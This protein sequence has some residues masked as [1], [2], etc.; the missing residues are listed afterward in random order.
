[1]K[2]YALHL[3]WLAFLGTLTVSVLLVA[4]CG[5][6]TSTSTSTLAPTSTPTHA[7]T[8]AATAPSG[9]IAELDV[10][11]DSN[12]IWREVFNS[13]TD[14]E[15]SCIREVLD[16]ELES[17][18]DR[19]LFGGFSWKVSLS[20]WK[21]TFIGDSRQDWEAQIYRCL[22]PATTRAIFLSMTISGFEEEGG[23]LSEDEESCLRVQIVDVD[24][25]D[26]IAIVA[27]E[28][29][30]AE[31]KQVIPGLVK[32]VP[33]VFLSSILPGMGVELEDL[34]EEEASCL[35]DWALSADWSVQY[36]ADRDASAAL[37]EIAPGMVKC[38]PDVFLSSILPGM[39]VELEDLSAE[40]ASCLRDWAL[41]ADWSVFFATDSDAS[42]ALAEFVPG[43]VGCVPRLLLPKDPDD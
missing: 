42:A 9:T 26:L 10:T 40:E 38:I 3:R 27:E 14:A 29:H 20:G 19:S 34:S 11:V 1:M 16:D 22:A 18:L 32:C 36:V 12:T 21:V 4:T 8:L 39:G 31:L 41:S 23:E 30:A 5:V 28:E 33:D 13:V 7:P 6:W 2:T 17:A 35:R 37:E 15:Q 43:I 25:A 24:V